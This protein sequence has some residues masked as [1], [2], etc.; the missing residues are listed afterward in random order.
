MSSRRRV[1]P[2]RSVVHY[3][4]ATTTA[5][6]PDLSKLDAIASGMPTGTSAVTQ[7]VVA[8]GGSA[9]GSGIPF[10]PPRPLADL[11]GEKVRRVPPGATAFLPRRPD[12]RTGLV[13]QY[14][15][16]A[17]PLAIADL[18]TALSTFREP[19]LADVFRVIEA[20]PAGSAQD[21]P[22]RDSPV[23]TRKSRSKRKSRHHHSLS[24]SSSSTSSSQAPAVVD[25]VDDSV[26]LPRRRRWRDRRRTCGA[27]I[28]RG[29]LP[30]ASVSP[31]AALRVRGGGRARD[32]KSCDWPAAGGDETG[33]GRVG[34]GEAL[35]YCRQ[36]LCGRR[37]P[38][39]AAGCRRRRYGLRGLCAFGVAGASEASTCYCS[40]AGVGKTGGAC[41]A[42]LCGGARCRRRRYG[43]RRLCV[44]G[45]VGGR[46]RRPLVSA[47]LEASARPAAPARG[48]HVARRVAAGVGMAGGGSACWGG[49]AG[50]GGD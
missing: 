33:G 19:L 6:P 11:V 4:L 2:R 25:R 36:R 16:S 24:S 26:C 29:G 40:V 14:K 13:D 1:F 20:S 23:D 9:A 31:A 15:S 41:W 32:A 45:G 34:R 44:L 17:T 28:G 10:L 35:V 30:P 5:S 38:F 27:G 3:R 18:D 46:G 49:R 22:C 47:S 48:G 42:R 12:E 37:R 50:E 39:G 21:A 7:A 43:R 8:T